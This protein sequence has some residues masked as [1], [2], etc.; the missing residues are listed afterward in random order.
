MPHPN[1]RVKRSGDTHLPDVE[2]ELALERR[3]HGLLYAAEPGTESAND[4]AMAQA[5]QPPA[6]D[7]AVLAARRV[8]RP[9]WLDAKAPLQ[10]IALFAVGAVVLSS[11]LPRRR[12]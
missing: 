7:L 2:S 5:P 4:V 12:A 3:K 11:L 9:F 10:A 1:G 6:G 8:N